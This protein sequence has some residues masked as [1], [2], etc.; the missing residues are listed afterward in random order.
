MRVPD[1]TSNEDFDDADPLGDGKSDVD[2]FLA[3]MHDEDQ[4]AAE[5][6]APVRAGWRRVDDWRDQCWL[7]EQLNDWDDWKDEDSL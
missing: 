4:K 2:D 3:S 1:K 6:D 7:R 5:P